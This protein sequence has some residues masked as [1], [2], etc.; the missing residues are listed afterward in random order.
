[1]IR[2]SGGFMDGNSNAL[3]AAWYPATAGNAQN[4]A[5][6]GDINFDSGES[7]F[8]TP[9]SFLAVATHEIGH[10]LGLGHT[11]ISGSLMYPYY[12][13]AITK[14][15]ADDIAGIRSIYG[16]PPGAE[17]VWIN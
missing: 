1:M 11:S 13:A 14:P 9:S 8:W 12:N 4:V 15:Q 3:A 2:I 5:L 6:S 17:G 16:L 7:S 10:S